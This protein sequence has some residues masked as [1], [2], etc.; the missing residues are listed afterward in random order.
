V[1][2]LKNALSS[3]VYKTMALIGK[4]QVADGIK[5]DG[6]ITAFTDLY[7]K[8][9]QAIWFPEEINVGLDVVDYKAMSEKEVTL[10]QDLVWYFVTSELLVQNVLGESFYPY[11]MDPRAKMSMT[12]QMFME[13]IHSD[14]FEM[15]LNT[16]NMDRDAIYNRSSNHPMMKEKQ[17]IV[18]KAANAISISNGW[19]NP[20]TIEGKKQILN[21]ILVNSIVQ[22]WIFFYSAFAMYFAMRET[23]KMRNV[24]NGMDLV[25]I[26]EG[27]HLKMGIEMILTMI[28][29]TPELVQDAAFVQHIQQTIVDS[30]EVELRF[31]KSLLDDG[32]TFGVTYNEMA[33]Y[34]KYIADRRLEELG[35][36]PHYAITANPLK[37]LQKQDLKTLQNFFEVTPN[38]YTN[39]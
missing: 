21:A 27:L 29:E 31:V 18:A 12:V 5:L 11:I 19:V 33:D 22:E 7:K 15:I 6:R 32:I 20:D 2:G 25:L 8:Q 3:Y 4:K 9:K 14:F 30:V 39:F 17:E 23:G 16:F 13:D 36:P 34:I 38:Q 26:D 37:F 1:V 10:F 28:E 24:C 35:F